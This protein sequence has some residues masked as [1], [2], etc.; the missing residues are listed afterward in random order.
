MALKHL[1]KRRHYQIIVILLVILGVTTGSAQAAQENED[2]TPPEKEPISTRK[3]SDDHFDRLFEQ[4][5]SFM[6]TDGLSQS[7]NDKLQRK[8]AEAEKVQDLTQF[9]SIIQEE[10]NRTS[11]TKPSIK[12][13]NSNEGSPA[14]YVRLWKV[15]SFV[16][17]DGTPWKYTS[18]KNTPVDSKH[19][20]LL[21]TDTPDRSWRLTVR[22]DAFTDDSQNINNKEV[23]LSDA[24]LNLQLIP[25]G[26]N[27][28][29]I[30]SP[31]EGV[32]DKGSTTFF[33]HPNNQQVFI[34][35]RKP[36]QSSVFSTTC[37]GSTLD[38]HPTNLDGSFTAN[39]IFTVS[40]T[41]QS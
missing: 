21:V 28:L 8:L 25:N 26:N 38:L 33:L 17:N 9:K 13:F 23:L 6:N 27:N 34:T 20:K 30:P 22:L 35:E 41:P 12:V 11:G 39:L 1:N 36:G 19:N 7:A 14:S 24:V 32:Q 40:S 16:F 29:P 31:S 2:T 15:P 10:L 5:E 4:A 37:T 18:C 3:N